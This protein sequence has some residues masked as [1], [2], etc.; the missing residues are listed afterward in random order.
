MRER[1][2]TAAVDLL[3]QCGHYVCQIGFREKFTSP[4]REIERVSL[5]HVL[6]CASAD[7]YA[8][9]RFFYDVDAAEGTL[10]A[11]G[12]TIVVEP[13]FTVRFAN[14]SPMLG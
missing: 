14:Q 12:M 8:R 7:P 1:I 2:Y 13:S 4:V 5:D 9:R 11:H 3:A 10:F 6:Q